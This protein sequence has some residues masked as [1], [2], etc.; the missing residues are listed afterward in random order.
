MNAPLQTGEQH[1]FVCSSYENRW[2]H[3]GHRYDNVFV[4][5]FVHARDP[6]ASEKFAAAQFTETYLTEGSLSD[7]YMLDVVKESFT[8][9]EALAFARYLKEKHGSEVKIES[10]HNPIPNNCM[11]DGAT[12][13]GGTTDIHMLNREDG[14]T[15]PFLVWGRYNVA[16]APL[17]EDQGE[18]PKDRANGAESV[19]QNIYT[20]N[21]FIVEEDLRGRRVFTGYQE[22]YRS[23]AL[24]LRFC[25]TREDLP[26]LTDTLRGIIKDIDIL[27]R[28]F[29][30]KRDERVRLI[31][32]AVH[33]LRGTLD[34]TQL[35]HPDDARRVV[36]VF[37][38]EEHKRPTRPKYEDEDLPF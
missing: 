18:A 36:E 16:E 13:C 11:P 21:V 6:K 23:A 4:S 3:R 5:W 37:S 10:Q 8:A 22:H 24:E 15:L 1:L 2:P 9:E 29:E 20:P 28:E 32:D 7:P 38:F 27:Y 26:E 31:S 14:Y 12:T 30:K 19:P 34:T 25:G 33:K 35:V 17:S